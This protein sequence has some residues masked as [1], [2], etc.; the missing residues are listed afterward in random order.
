KNGLGVA[1]P[2]PKTGDAPQLWVTVDE[3]APTV[4]VTEC[5][6]GY[7]DSLLIGWT[8]Q[9]VHLAD[10]PIT[11]STAVCKE[12]PW[13][14]VASG[15]ANTG[16]HVWKMPKDL[17]FEFYVKVE[18]TDS[19]GNVGGDHT[20]RPVR[21]DLCKPHGTLTGVDNEKKLEVK[22]ETVPQVLEFTT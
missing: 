14:T 18:A 22:N 21:V 3:T 6:V 11:I 16:R 4:Q 5:A 17:P 7:G 2:A 9:D 10:T 12:G 8:A 19:A 15:L 13:T 20:A 1:S